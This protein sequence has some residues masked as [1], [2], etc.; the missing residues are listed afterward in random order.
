M[1]WGKPRARGRDR[2]GGGPTYHEG[3]AW[4]GAICPGGPPFDLGG[5]MP[6]ARLNWIAG[7]ILYDL[8]PGRPGAGWLGIGKESRQ[9]SI[10]QRKEK[11]FVPALAP[12]R[13]GGKTVGGGSRVP[14]KK[15]VSG[16]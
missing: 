5:L 4:A 15:D 16:R 10:R 7:F 3:K 9:R 2:P 1:A 11:N 8:V 14:S 12:G 6:S 13:T